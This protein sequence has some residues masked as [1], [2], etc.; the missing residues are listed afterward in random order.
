MGSLAH[1]Q[2]SFALSFAALLSVASV[3]TYWVWLF[4]SLTSFV[5]INEIGDEDDVEAE[6]GRNFLYGLAAL[7]HI[8]VFGLT[9]TSFPRSELRGKDR[10]ARMG[11]QKGHTTM[12]MLQRAAQRRSG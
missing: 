3:V 11:E 9:A 12:L 10:H 7:I 8:S 5:Q 4:T 6:S 1:R 2:R